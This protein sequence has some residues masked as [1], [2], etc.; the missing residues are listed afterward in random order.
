MRWD[1]NRF[2]VGRL[3]VSFLGVLNLRCVSG[4]Q[5]GMSS[6]QLEFRG[7]VQAGDVN[8]EVVSI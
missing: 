4:I 3:V 5:V 2:I 6:M 7:K 8:L 1:K